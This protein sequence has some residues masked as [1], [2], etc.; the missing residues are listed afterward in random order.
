[1]AQAAEPTYYNP[2]AVAKATAQTDAPIAAYKDGRGRFET[3][4]SVYAAPATPAIGQYETAVNIGSSKSSTVSYATAKEGRFDGRDTIYAKPA[5]PGIGE[6]ETAVHMASAKSSTVSYATAKE[7]RFEGRDTIYAKPATPGIGEYE[8]AVPFNIG[9]SKSS[10]I[11]YAKA[12]PH[13]LSRT[14]AHTPT[15]APQDTM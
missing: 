6:Y 11:S 1:M 4:D 12:R 7:G 10:T 3:H 13:A 15:H 5:T 2:S 14:C 8:T 9:S